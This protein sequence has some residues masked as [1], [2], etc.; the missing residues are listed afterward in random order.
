MSNPIEI[1]VVTLLATFV[2]AVAGTL[3]AQRAAERNHNKRE[4]ISRI[5]KL[6]LA[7]SHAFSITNHFISI[8]RQFII[9]IHEE[10]QINKSKYY[11][12]KFG[13]EAENTIHANFKKMPIASQ[14]CEFLYEL[15]KEISDINPKAI[16]AAISLTESWLSLDSI[17]KAREKIIDRFGSGEFDSDEMAK[18]QMYLGIK[19]NQNSFSTEY[20]DSVNGMLEACD[21]CIYFSKKFGNSLEIIRDTDVRDAW[22]YFRYVAK[23]KP[24][25]DFSN[26]LQWL[27]KEE[28]FEDWNK[29]FSTNKGRDKKS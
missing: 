18:I 15:C 1:F 19:D 11:L 25:A 20:P 10:L 7:I 14:D 8:K 4:L 26:A 17:R 2:G 6:N 5:S 3:A 9:P 12:T 28:D 23:T 16:N 22:Y 29:G 13:Y 21:A 27:P 24:K